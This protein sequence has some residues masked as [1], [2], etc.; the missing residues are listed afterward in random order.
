MLWPSFV[1]EQHNT[2]DSKCNFDTPLCCDDQKPKSEQEPE[3][4]TR[5]SGE[6]SSG[7]NDTTWV[8]VLWVYLEMPRPVL[9]F[10]IITHLSAPPDANLLPSGEK[11]TEYIDPSWPSIFCLIDPD[12]VLYNNNWLP[13]VVTRTSSFG[14]SARD[15]MGSSY[16]T[17]YYLNLMIY[18]WKNRRHAHNLPIL[19]Q[20]ILLLLP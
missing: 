14:W 13:E 8:E 10:Q 1:H 11:L 18:R 17:Q 5:P 3:K 4:R 20:P 2:F 16:A 7:Q 9:L 6:E 12:L 15:L 19:K